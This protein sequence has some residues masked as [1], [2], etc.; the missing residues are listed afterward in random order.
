MTLEERLKE[1]EAKLAAA[2]AERD[3]NL[4]MYRLMVKEYSEARQDC[5][6]MAE[7]LDHYSKLEDW[8]LLPVIAREALT[9]ER[10]EKYLK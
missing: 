6:V 10:R 9:P 3:E 7:A 2:E 8:R 1:T 5:K 4:K